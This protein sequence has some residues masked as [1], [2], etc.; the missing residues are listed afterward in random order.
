MP[1]G[2][3]QIP[4]DC[5]LPIY[6]PSNPGFRFTPPSLF[7]WNRKGFCCLTP[8]GYPIF[9]GEAYRF[10]S[11]CDLSYLCIKS[12]LKGGEFW[13]VTIRLLLAS[14]PREMRPF[15]SFFKEEYPSK[16]KGE[17]VVASTT[18]RKCALSLKPQ[19]I[20]RHS[21]SARLRLS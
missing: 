6:A 15:S 14:N 5:A 13:T 21:A 10:S 1:A 17:V 7:R 16:A 2:S 3:I 18:H 9:L 4:S 20:S 8:L 12:S 19:K 11:S